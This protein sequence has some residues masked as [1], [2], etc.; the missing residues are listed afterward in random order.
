MSH[1]LC[2][3]IIHAWLSMPCSAAVI[4]VDSSF[5]QFRGVIDAPQSLIAQSLPTPLGATQCL[6]LID[7]G[8]Q[9]QV[10]THLVGTWEKTTTPVFVT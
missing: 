5:L 4:A 3:S 9:N 1:C 6:R 7:V 8:T 2:A 10:W